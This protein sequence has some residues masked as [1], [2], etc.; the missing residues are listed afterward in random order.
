[1]YRVFV[2]ALRILWWTG[3]DSLYVQASRNLLWTGNDSVYVEALLIHAK[4]R[5]YDRKRLR[6]GE[7]H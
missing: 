2:H 4:K 1:M 7:K 3:K 6:L 5:R